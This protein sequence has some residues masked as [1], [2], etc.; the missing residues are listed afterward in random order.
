MAQKRSKSSAAGKK[1]RR[2]SFELGLPGVMG[3]GFI[4]VLIMVWAFILGILV[5]RGY[6]PE[7]V[8]PDIGR[9]VSPQ[10]PFLSSPRTVLQPEEL[11]FHD[12]L[13]ERGS[14][15]APIA[16]RRPEPPAPSVPP[17]SHQVSPSQ[18]SPPA[19][20]PAPAATTPEPQQERF[21]F[22]YQVASFQTEPQARAL[23]Q[24]IAAVGLRAS[25]EAGLVDGRQWYRVLVTVRGGQGEADQARAR[26]QAIGVADPFLRAK[27][28][29]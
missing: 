23:Q 24:Q 8:I 6:H 13:Q 1:G 2:W 28:S 27:K 16:P 5:G 12:T 11:R 14:Q 7:S 4:G 18:E 17:P 3:V 22:V 21:E 15:P 10:E 29:L 20:P 9:I 26:L 25:V 19:P